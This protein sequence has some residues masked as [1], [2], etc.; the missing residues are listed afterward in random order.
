MATYVNGRR[1]EHQGRTLAM[2]PAPGN[3]VIPK[4][5]NAPPVPIPNIA[6]APG[7]QNGTATLKIDRNK[8]SVEG[9]RFDSHPATPDRIS[10]VAGVK[11]GVVGGAAE[12][13][14]FSQDTKFEAKGSVRSFDSTKSNSMVISPGWAQKL[15]LKALPDPYGKLILLIYEKLPGAFG[16]QLKALGESALDPANL[17]G[18]A[19]KLIGKLI[20]GVNLVVGGAAMAQAGME[21]SALA[22][23]IKELMTPPM[24]DEKLNKIADIA[25]DGIAATTI[26]FVVGKSVGRLKKPSK[27][28]NR[29]DNQVNPNAKGKIGDDVHAPPLANGA[30]CELGTCKPVIFAT[31]VKIINDEDFQLPGIIALNWT[32]FYRSS[33]R[34]PGWLGYG[35]STPFNIELTLSYGHT[36]FYDA[37]G[38]LVTLPE[39]EL[40][41]SH[42]DPREKL[43]LHRQPDG[44]YAIEWPSGLRHEFGT[45]MPGQWRLPVRRIVDRHHNAIT[46][47]YPAFDSV[48]V[49]NQLPRPIGLT[50]S[51]GRYLSFVWNAKG[52][53]EEVRL[54]PRTA[55]GV[56]YSGGTLVRYAYSTVGNLDDDSHPNLVAVTDA[57]GAAH[58]YRYQNHLMVAYTTKTGFTHH[59]QWDRLD[60]GGRVVRTWTDEPGLL[61]TQFEYLLNERTTRITDAMG[62]TSSYH[63]NAHNEVTAITESGADGQPVRVETQMD[64]AGNPVQTADALGRSTQFQ[65]D[66]AG[67]LTS[68]TDAA[69]ASSRFKYNTLN[70]PTEVIDALGG[71]WRNAYDQFG[72]LL[73]H[74]DALEYTTSYE[75]DSRGLPITITDASGKPKRLQWDEAGQLITYTDCSSQTTRYEYD[76]LGNM[77]T[78]IDPLGQRT[79]YQHNALG[80][81]LQ[82]TQPDGAQHHYAYDANGNLIQYT[83]P[84]GATT[85]YVYNGL[86]QPIERQDA[87]GATLRYAYDAA[88]RLIALQN[89][90]LATYRFTYDEA[91]NLIEEIGFD[92]RIQRYRYNAAGELIELH[93]CASIE[94][95]AQASHPDSQLHHPRAALSKRTLFN[96]D[97]LGRL[98]SKRHETV[99]M[100]QS[101]SP[102]ATNYSYDALGRMASCFNTHAQ[103]DF[104]YDALSQLLQETQTHMVQPLQTLQSMQE[105]QFI[106]KHRYDALGNR[107]QTRLPS[108]K[109]VN[110]L[111]YG[112]GHLHQ[113]NIDGRIVSD[114]ERDALHREISRS[115][116]SLH[117][118]YQLDPMGRLSAHK[119]SRKSGMAGQGAVTSAQSL[120][121]KG[122]SA[123]KSVSSPAMPHLPNLP[124]LPDGTRITR[125]YGYDA[126]GNLTQVADNLRGT[127]HYRY[128]ALSRIRAA[129]RSAGS[130]QFDFDP[131]GNLL[132][133]APAQSGASS[134]S[135][136]DELHSR[137]V[138]N[139]RLAV[140]QDLR[141][142]YDVHG[143]I[144]TR[145][146]GWHTQQQFSYSVEHQITS[147]QIRRLH[148]KPEKESHQTKDQNSGK[149]HLPLRETVQEVHYAYDPLGR[150]IAKQDAFGITRFA[151]D[152]DLL[153]AELRGSRSNEYLYEPDSFVP[154]AKLEGTADW[155][156]KAL[157]NDTAQIDDQ[158]E[159][160]QER[161]TPQ[162][163][164]IYHYHCDQIGAPQELTDE[165]G[166]IVWATSYK[167]WG[168]TETLQ[169]LKTGTDDAVFSNNSTTLSPV[170]AKQS[171]QLNF[172]EQPLRF[173]GQYLDEETGLHYNR[174]RY[175]DPVTGRFIHQDPIG[176][177]GGENLYQYGPNSTE[178]I[179]PQGL[180]KHRNRMNKEVG[181]S[182]KHQTHHMIPQELFEKFP[183]LNCIDKDHLDNL[184][185]LPKTAGE[186]DGKKGKYFGKSTHN[187]NHHAYSKAIEGAIKRAAKK[188][189][190]CPKNLAKSLGDMQDLLRKKLKEGKPIMKSESASFDQWDKILR[191]GG[192]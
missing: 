172:I 48:A 20:P 18:P 74:T 31:G 83:D 54:L 78:S 190:G 179:D 42:F 138:P 122:A 88:G 55:Q 1:A 56:E 131:A 52:L 85:R 96:R 162:S 116:G 140:Y 160:E 165:Q 177:E 69:G 119:I 163:F 98:L 147:V 82:I 184:I 166:Q 15:L 104:A 124:H 154:L 191:R 108:G 142:E 59:Q 37:K 129:Q 148:D 157:A 102:A 126:A 17:V 143:N 136:I 5:G 44:Q 158:D 186:T 117:S 40:G 106:L 151:Y 13:T 34:R 128:D 90:N 127:S 93:E 72:N 70:L 144:T 170:Q 12:P 105:A 10:G 28:S 33:D 123:G 38:R 99:G 57:L 80:Q 156:K 9:S 68:V 112:S 141:F 76:S 35:W 25:A 164:A 174:Y 100:D 133:S 110:Y 120:W 92:G 149:D 188:A 43:T 39:L 53:L 132:N 155:F 45:P 26:G 7:L 64:S 130:E 58:H 169:Y 81:L 2:I 11:S 24:T 73:V 178:W 3:P 51:A 167:V 101:T 22:D 95:Q 97:V 113:I 61:D 114:I 189:G 103:V 30:T 27:V 161:E 16:D 67:N 176:L 121:D 71:K 192:F 139:N 75:Y 180:S 62:R 49:T 173:Q 6:H 150:R 8:V 145:R 4:P 171:T 86:D 118:H 66:A 111:H 89:E 107:I 185:N 181:K 183:A 94:E 91:D 50:D 47:H 115:Q 152:G 41:Q 168:Q 187:T 87:I 29:T 125:A 134:H 137:Q 14:S 153:T 23:E 84:L 146:I 46:I 159:E 65:F 135:T 182:P 175:Y 32:R 21:M 36:Y 77:V 109:R 60:A 79:S 63:Y 19:L